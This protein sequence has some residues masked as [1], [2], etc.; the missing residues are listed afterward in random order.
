MRGILLAVAALQQSDHAPGTGN[1][2]E[3]RHLR[4]KLSTRRAGKL[5]R[6]FF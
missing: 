2:F 3:R 5:Y 4:T 6:N 1:A